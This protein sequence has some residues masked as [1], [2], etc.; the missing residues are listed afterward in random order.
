ML[1]YGKITSDNL[2]TM[3]T[4]FDITQLIRKWYRCP[5]ENYGVAVTSSETT[6]CNTKFYTKEAGTNLKPYLRI[7]YASLAGLEDY[8]TY[9]S[10]GAGRAGTGNVSLVNGNMI[11]L[12]ADTE[13]NGARMPVC[14]T[15]VYN[16]CDSAS[17]SFGCGYGWRT[18]YHLTL[19]K[20]YLDS[21]I[22]Y[23]YTDGDGTEHWFKPVPAS[24]TTDYRD[25][26]GLSMKLKV[27]TNS[28]T[29]T[30]KGDNVMTFPK[31][32]A[33]PTAANP[34]T[35]KVL[36]STIA[37]ACGNAVTVSSTGMKITQIE[38][39]AGRITTFDYSGNYLSAIRTPWQ[40]GTD[41]VRFSYTGGRL[42]G[43]TYED[44]H[45]STFT[46]YTESGTGGH[47][48]LTSAAGPEGITAEFTYANTGA[49]GGLPHVVTET[50]VTGIR[51]NETLTGSHKSYDYGSR[52][53]VV[54]DLLT[55]NSIR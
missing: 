20:E 8:L 18:N 29:I 12:H 10:V 50:E 16:S 32:T 35:G 7:S 23:V 5:N 52:L 13:M 39:G 55:N 15:H 22:Y 17:N 38:D 46:Y 27:E 28:V 33:T 36:V 48:L 34:V 11:F 37:D 42:T 30:D 31:I 40:T 2:Y 14:V 47:R 21:K 44:D 24:S 6:P 25:E 26:S 4:Q 49:A 9:D 51:E 43:V 3:M 1:D 53:C 41:C 19:H 45:A 54:K